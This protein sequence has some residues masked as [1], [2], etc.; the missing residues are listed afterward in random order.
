MR[1]YQGWQTDGGA[2]VDLWNAAMGRDFP[3]D[4]R[5]WQQNMDFDPHYDPSGMLVAR[6]GDSLV[7]F[8]VA[9]VERFPL[10]LQQ[11]T[12][13]KGWISALA[14]LPTCQRRG[15]ATRLLRHA[16]QWL[17]GKKALQVTVGGGPGHFFPG[18]P[19]SSTSALAFFQSHGYEPVGDPCWDLQRDIRDFHPPTVTERVMR[20]NPS[21]YI[22]RCTNRS[23][24]ALLDFLRCSFPGRWLYE[25]Q[26]RLEGER[27]PQDI[28]ILRIGNRVV[29]F[30]HTWH[31]GSQRLGPSIYWRKLLK[32]TFG[33]LGPMGVSVDVRNTGLSFALL[34]ESIE[35]LRKLG[36]VSM[37]IDWT[38][39][40]K[41]YG[42]AGFRPWKE[43][44]THGLVLDSQ[45]SVPMASAARP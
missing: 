26:L 22:T 12:V 11:L 38:V 10:G 35:Y 7:G 30:A 21:F 15:T 27:S 2:V 9:R 44:S 13:G 23:V 32:P 45:T 43:Y 3:M 17:R 37:V 31:K 40:L 33:G 16:Y 1:S 4:L 18:I 24:P 41:F 28:T 6:E 25:T 39:L 36:V 8:I 34:C 19:H 42:A 5:L 29:G 14:V 20:R